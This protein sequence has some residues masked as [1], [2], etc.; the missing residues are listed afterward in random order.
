MYALSVIMC[1]NI[2]DVLDAITSTISITLAQRGLLQHRH[3]EESSYKISE[4]LEPSST[5]YTLIGR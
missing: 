3:L 1:L 2:V 4:F 5:K